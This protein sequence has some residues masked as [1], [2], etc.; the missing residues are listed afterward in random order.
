MT[1]IVGIE[2]ET[3]VE[4]ISGYLF[5]RDDYFQPFD[6]IPINGGKVR[7][8]MLLIA[9]NKDIIREKHGGVIGT[10]TSVHS[11]QGMIVARVAKEFGFKCIVGVGGTEPAMAIKHPTIRKAMDMGAEIVKVAGIGYASIIH[12]KLVEKYPN[13]YPV[14][15]GINLQDNPAAILESTARQVSNLP[16]NLDYLVAPVGSGVTLAGII[17]GLLKKHDRPKKLIA[18]QIAGVERRESIEKMLPIITVTVADAPKYNLVSPVHYR[19]E[20]HAI[21]GIPYFKRIKADI[22]GIDL[23]GIYEAKAFNF[24]KNTLRLKGKICFW[25]VG[26]TNVFF[27]KETNINGESQAVSIVPV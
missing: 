24:M 16:P 1:R 10:T 21:Q 8:A 26:N 12:K 25:V 2:T 20:Y 9:N 4:E 14:K 27:E 22:D 11:A 18:I 23:D 3:P 7:Q 6:D 17:R 15:F 5:K 19:Y 13:L